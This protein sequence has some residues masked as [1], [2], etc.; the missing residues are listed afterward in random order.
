[1]RLRSW[2]EARKISED[3][4]GPVLIVIEGPFGGL[5][6]EEI[7]WYAKVGWWYEIDRR[8]DGSGMRGNQGAGADKV[9]YVRIQGAGS[10]RSRQLKWMV[11]L[12][13]LLM[14][15]VGQPVPCYKL[16]V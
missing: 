9:E 11:L 1:M 2:I 5:G 13:Q 15:P 10:K 7:A 8:C 12:V 3:E 16:G 6:N 14:D 4:A